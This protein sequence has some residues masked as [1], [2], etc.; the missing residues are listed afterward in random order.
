MESCCARSGFRSGLR[1]WAPCTLW[2]SARMDRR[3]QPGDGPRALNGELSNLHIRPRV[4]K[5][6]SANCTTI[7]LMSLISSRSRQTAA[8]SPQRSAV[9]MACGSSTGTRIGARR[10]ATINTETKVMARR[11]RATAVS[12]RRSFD[13]LIRSY[14]YDPNSDSPNFRRVG[15]P[16]KAPSG[17]RPRGV[18]YSPDGKLLAVGYS[19]VA[20]VD[21][22]DG[23]TLERV[24]GHKP[25][26]VRPSPV[27]L[28]YVA[29]S[30]DGQTLF[31]AG[32]VDRRPR[33]ASPFR[34][35]SGRPGRREAHD[36]L[37]S[38]YGRRRRRPAGRANPCRLDGSPASAS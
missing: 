15:E 34:V 33:P 5:P 38:R 25:A 24:G 6:R 3:S 9:A 35:G 13:G 29:W 8:T 21:V 4:R 12:R 23:T 36:L 31:A 26:D 14:Q 17:N 30:R 19:D 28:S 18:A 1:T 11:S 2:R 16:F 10:S 27:E 37:R 20:A 22:L 32:A 7:S